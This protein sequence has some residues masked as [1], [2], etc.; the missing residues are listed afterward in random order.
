MNLSELGAAI[1]AVCPSFE[2]I[3]IIDPSDRSTWRIDIGPGATDAERQA[4]QQAMMGYVDAAPVP[5]VISDR[6]F[7]QQLALLGLITQAEAIAAVGT[8]AIP[9]EMQGALTGS[10]MSADEQ[11]AATM[12]LTGATSFDRDDPL[13]AV[14]AAA[15]NPPLTPAQIA[16]IWSAAALL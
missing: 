15:Q 7:Y 10:G 3:A 16:A 8:G 12:K 4:A 14:F 11:F 13:V 9:K 2:G 5:S 6:Q 1:S